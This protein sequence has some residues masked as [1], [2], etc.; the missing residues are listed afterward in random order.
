MW[1]NVNDKIVGSYPLPD[2][3]NARDKAPVAELPLPGELK[4]IF[5]TT[6][7]CVKIGFLFRRQPFFAL[8]FKKISKTIDNI[9]FQI[10]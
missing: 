5:I 6:L 3:G 8:Y 7:T 9:L 10:Q 1:L 2:G 4:K